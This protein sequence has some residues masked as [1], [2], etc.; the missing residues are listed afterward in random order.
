[1][2]AAM[3]RGCRSYDVVSAGDRSDT[4]RAN[5]AT[6][7]NARPERTSVADSGM[8]ARPL[9]GGKIPAELATRM[10]GAA[11]TRMVIRIARIT[12]RN[13]EAPRFTKI[14]DRSIGVVAA[15]SRSVPIRH[16]AMPSCCARSRSH[17][18]SRA[19]VVFPGLTKRAP[20]PCRPGSGPRDRPL[21]RAEPLSLTTNFDCRHASLRVPHGRCC[22]R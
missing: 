10:A 15:P 5:R 14:H 8:A 1:M 11:K 2:G 3:F 4:R 21:V 6:S 9:S 18:R 22:Y 19:G 20:T 13:T 12:T 16:P 17:R 7:I